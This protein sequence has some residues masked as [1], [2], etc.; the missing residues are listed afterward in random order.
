M[1][2][3]EFRELRVAVEVILIVYQRWVLLEVTS[4]LRMGIEEL[5]DG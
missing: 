5:I 4:D 3:Q 2:L 1:S